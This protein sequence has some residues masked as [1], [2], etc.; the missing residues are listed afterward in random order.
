MRPIRQ[1][2]RRAYRGEAGAGGLADGDY[3]DIT[4]SGTGTVMSIDA[5]VV[6][7]T[8]LA[9]DS[10]TYAKIQDV[11]AT[12]R[13][14]GRSTAGAG[15]VEEITCT[16]AGRALLDD[17]SA[18][19]QLVTLGAAAASHTHVL[20]DLSPAAITDGYLLTRDGA[21]WTGTDPAGLGNGS[22]PSYGQVLT[23][24]SFGGY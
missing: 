14:L 18:A 3:G 9:D 16:A 17:A 11:S 12:D 8:E 15:V 19:A 6:G 5:G 23:M 20:G 22:G 1:P 7:T 10:V 2:Q 24:I 13:L 4:V 21:G